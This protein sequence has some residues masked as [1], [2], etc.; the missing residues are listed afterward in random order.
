VDA[1]KNMLLL[2]LVVIT[3]IG[4]V[5]GDIIIAESCH[6]HTEPYTNKV[7]ASEILEKI[8]RSEPVNY[9]HVIIEGDLNLSDLNLSQVRVNRS[10]YQLENF[11]LSEKQKQVSVPVI[12]EDSL[13]EGSIDFSNTYLQRDISFFRSH[14]FGDVNF[15]KSYFNQSADFISGTVDGYVYFDISHFEQRVGFNDCHFE[16]DAEFVGSYFNN[17]SVFINSFFNSSADFTWSYFSQPVNFSGT[18]FKFV[19]F[20]GSYFEQSAD[21][22]QV[23]FNQPADFSFSHF[24]QS[25]FFIF[26]H[27]NQS[28][29]F[30]EV[31]FNFS[32]FWNS[33]FSY[34]SDFSGTIFNQ[35]TFFINT[36]FDQ[37][38]DF[39]GTDFNQAVYFNGSKFNQSVKFLGAHF[40]ESAYFSDSHFSQSADFS[41]DVFDKSTYFINSSFNKVAN[42]IGTDFNQAVYFNGS[43][44]N[45]SVKFLGAHFNESAYFSDSHFSQSADFSRS[46]LRSVDFNRTTFSGDL[47][48]EGTQI[49][50]LNLKNAE[51][52]KIVLKSWKSIGH[53]EYDEM[54]YQLLISNFR[55][56]NLPEAANDCYYDYRNDRRATLSWLYQPADY[57]LM[58]FYG[59]GVKPD[60]PISWSFVFIALFAGLFWWRQGI[61][62]LR[63]GEPEEEAKRF[64]LPEALAF[65]A[66]T[67]LSGG[68]LVF[69]P[70][71]YKIAPGRPWRD[72][73]ISKALFILER[74]LG[75]VLVIMF[76]IAVGKTIVLGG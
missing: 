68:K 27:F 34:T 19:Y 3:I 67:F 15:S 66:M 48:F 41:K 14:V 52:S 61:L 36:Y 21:F 28:A 30:S 26:S 8:E 71:E 9:C 7:Q 50:S 73:Q 54:A 44:F 49:D 62:P 69:D 40:N 42:F 22:M 25:A 35:S 5:N 59:Y 70:P 76:A 20:R 6:N 63:E 46:Y 18:N 58:R 57:A 37:A 1:Q 10:R 13:I 60:R 56:Q 23:V 31:E 16:N 24:N 45:Q 55:N 17:S 47:S 39:I 4:A 43:K 32:S 65:S 29:D 11:D 72:V 51:F 2:T 12:I 75:M 74:L 53:M 33:S 64:T 38:A